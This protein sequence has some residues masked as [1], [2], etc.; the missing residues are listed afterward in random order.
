M[1]TESKPG[2]RDPAGMD[3]A[4]RREMDEFGGEGPD[5]EDFGDDEEEEDEHF[6]T[7][8][9][10]EEAQKQQQSLPDQVLMQWGALFKLSLSDQRFLQKAIGGDRL[11]E[12]T[13]I[14][15][16]L[17]T[18]EGSSYN[19]DEYRQLESEIFTN[20]KLDFLQCFTMTFGYFY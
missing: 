14:G 8:Q 4:S 3:E 2:D 7:D 15:F 17:K 9:I 13:N 10:K 6:L 5:E 11:Q 12:L 20:E 16:D 1:A 19:S 18:W